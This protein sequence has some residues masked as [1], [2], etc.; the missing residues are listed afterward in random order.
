LADRPQGAVVGSL[1]RNWHATTV[2]RPCPAGKAIVAVSRMC[3]LDNMEGQTSV[4]TF[5]GETLGLT[6]EDTREGLT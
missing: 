6:Q 1:A 3:R 2:N 4:E 5:L